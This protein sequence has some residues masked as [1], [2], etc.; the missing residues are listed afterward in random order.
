MH[1]AGVFLRK[2]KLKRQYLTV[3]LCCYLK[4]RQNKTCYFYLTYSALQPSDFERR[5][6]LSGALCD[7]LWQAGNQTRCCVC[8][9]QDVAFFDTDY[10]YRV[11]GFTEKVYL[12]LYILFMLFINKR[13]SAIYWSF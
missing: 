3:I 13:S 5:K 11:D 1:R 7:V 8:L 9:Q 2:R 10:Q 4:P 12:F 6:A